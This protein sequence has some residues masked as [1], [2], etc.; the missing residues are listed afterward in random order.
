MNMLYLYVY[1]T[2]SMTCTQCLE[3]KED[4]TMIKFYKELLTN[5]TTLYLLIAIQLT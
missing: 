3:W 2:I 4:K 5:R 1:T